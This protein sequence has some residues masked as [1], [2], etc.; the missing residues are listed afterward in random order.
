M[1]PLSYFIDTDFSRAVMAEYG[2]YLQ[3]I[4]SDINW[5]QSLAST[6]DNYTLESACY[7][8]SNVTTYSQDQRVLFKL[9]LDLRMQDG[10]IDR[11]REILQEYA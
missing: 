11:F 1:R 7:E 3:N 10:T 2:E 6:V 9:A 8:N 5:L 4:K